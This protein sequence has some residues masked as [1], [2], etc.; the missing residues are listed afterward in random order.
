MAFC[1]FRRNRLSRW[2]LL[3]REQTVILLEIGLMNSEVGAAS[4]SSFVFVVKALRRT[5]HPAFTSVFWKCTKM[6]N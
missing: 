1:L 5:R 2:L 4:A 3:S 6:C